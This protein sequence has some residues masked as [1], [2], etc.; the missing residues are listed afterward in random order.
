MADDLVAEL[1]PVDPAATRLRTDDEAQDVGGLIQVVAPLIVPL[2]KVL[3][4]WLKATHKVKLK[5]K[6]P[7]GS[8]IEADN[9]TEHGMLRLTELAHAHDHKR[10]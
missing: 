3:V 4:D 2:A 8:T 10:R 6:L 5:M 1:R 7:D 9:M